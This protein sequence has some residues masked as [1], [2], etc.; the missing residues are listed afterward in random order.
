MTYRPPINLRRWQRDL[1]ASCEDL[2]CA[3]AAEPLSRAA[4]IA[5][6]VI[7]VMGCLL[8]WVLQ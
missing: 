4:L 3:E 2:T 8:C 6:L 5:T 1:L 7:L